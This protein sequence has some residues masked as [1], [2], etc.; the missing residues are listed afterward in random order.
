MMTSRSSLWRGAWIETLAAALVAFGARRSSL[1]RGAWI[2]TR[3]ASSQ[4]PGKSC[5][6]SLWR[7]AW[8]E[9]VMPMTYAI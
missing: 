7:G 4:L 6:S 5:R 3:C 1:W 9:T 2:E 8:I